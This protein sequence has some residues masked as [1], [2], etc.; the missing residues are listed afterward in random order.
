MVLSHLLNLQLTTDIQVFCRFPFYLDR[1]LI[2]SKLWI[3]ALRPMHL[4]FISCLLTIISTVLVGKRLWQGWIMAGINS[5]II[6]LIGFQTRQWG[7]ILANIFCLTIYAYNIGKWRAPQG[8]ASTVK[9]LKATSVATD[10]QTESA[11]EKLT[12]FHQPRRLAGRLRNSVSSRSRHQLKR[13]K[14]S[15]AEGSI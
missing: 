9:P 3:C 11:P 14:D 1:A 2:A 6:C 12:M 5:M 7:L 8:S 13:M 4:D 10:V 15:S